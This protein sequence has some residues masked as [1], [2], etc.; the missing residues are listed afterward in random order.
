MSRLLDRIAAA[1]GILFVPLV[2]LGYGM[3]ISSYVP[4]SL[5]TPQ[6]VADFFATH[7][8]DAGFWVGVA[9]ESV[10]ML[11]LLLFAMRL[12]GRIRAAQ[13][14]DGWLAQAA[15]AALVIALSVKYSSFAPA[16]AGQ[17]HHERYDAGTV[18]A[19]MDI[20][21]AA[22]TLSWV[23]I[24]AFILLTGMGGL[25][26]AALPQWLCVGALVTGGALVI[27]LIVPAVWDTVLLLTLL[28]LIAGSVVLLRHGPSIRN[29]PIVPAAA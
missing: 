2:G 29:A 12:L 24:G 5:E 22:Y 15:S 25:V 3:F 10:G 19:L 28:W 18:A 4:E 11:L 27:A 14:A 1:G 20:N 9:M 7:P 26:T 21:E 23:G 8:V 17:L 16:L 13:A 6:A